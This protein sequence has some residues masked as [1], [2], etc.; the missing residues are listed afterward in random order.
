MDNTSEQTQN[1]KNLSPVAAGITG[2]VIGVVG[3]TAAVM[4]DKPTRERFTK[5]AKTMADHMKEWSD[6]TLHEL[7]AKGE[8]VKKKSASS[9]S[10]KLDDVKTSSA[11]AA[12]EAKKRL[13]E[14]LNEDKKEL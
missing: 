11:N 4:S 14:A 3:A 13:E 6:N 12:D 5:K 8:E 10:D 2:F 1:Q 9:A 7:K